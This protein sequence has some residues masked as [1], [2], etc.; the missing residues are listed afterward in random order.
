MTLTILPELQSLIPPLTPEEAA[1][2]EANI[3]Q[4]GC[5]TPL[6]V[7]HETQT[8]LDGHNRLRICEAHGIDYHLQEKSLPDMD[9]AQLWILRHQRGRR[10][11]TPDQLSYN[12]GKEYEI[13]KRQGRRTDL[14]SGNSCQKFTST[15]AALGQEHQVSEKTIRNDFAYAQAVDTLAA[16]LGDAVRERV[17]D[18]EIKLTQQDVKTLAKIATQHPSAAS[19][20]IAAVREVKTPKQARQIVREKV[21]VAREHQAYMDAIARSNCPEEDWPPSLRPKPTPTPADGLAPRLRQTL[22]S[23]EVLHTCLQ[24]VSLPEDLAPHREAC[25]ALAQAYRQIEPLLGLQPEPPA[26]D[27]PDGPPFDPAK[28]VLG[29][30][31]PQRHAYG[32]TGQSLRRI[33]D[34]HCLQC[35]A[36]KSRQTRQ[37]QKQAGDAPAPEASELSA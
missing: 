35:D 21:R 18:H 19:E 25:L 29:T 32:Q 28:Y 33:R 20:A 5:L 26:Q 1:Q 16:T 3:L 37:R 14:T 12:R 11:L 7:W 8:L 23:L 15:A 17:R 24:L 6:I 13:Q 9:A 36:E 27:T 2:L 30:L 31:C 10:N 34:R 22:H 4:D